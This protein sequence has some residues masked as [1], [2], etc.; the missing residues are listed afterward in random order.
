MFTRPLHCP[1]FD[2]AFV[3]LCPCVLVPVEREFSYF[4]PWGWSVE[5]KTLLYTDHSQEGEKHI[6]ADC[7]NVP[8]IVL[9]KLIFYYNL[10][11]EVSTSGG[12]N[13]LHSLSF[14]QGDMII[15]LL[16]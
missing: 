1:W 12:W 15:Y 4:L 6:F 11:Q 13:Q 5:W 9:I 2:N 8:V 10:I 3:S 14:Y 16:K 7:D